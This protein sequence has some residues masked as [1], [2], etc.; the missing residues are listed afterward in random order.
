MYIILHCVGRY[1]VFGWPAVS[2]VV[3]ARW[4]QAAH[5]WCLHYKVKFLFLWLADNLW[6]DTLASCNIKIFISYL[7]NDFSIHWWS[8]S[9]SIILLGEDDLLAVFEDV[10]LVSQDTDSLLSL[11]SVG[12]VFFHYVCLLLRAAVFG[13]SSGWPNYLNRA[14][15]EFTVILQFHHTS[16]IS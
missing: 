12:H 5:T 13:P 9:E 10:V 4:C 2:D 8:Y 15:G 11:D 16:Y 3:I 7:P 14:H 1:L 6:V